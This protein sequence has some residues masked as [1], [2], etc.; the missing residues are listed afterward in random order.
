MKN[1]RAK[2]A[3]II[4]SIVFVF[5][6]CMTVFAV[7]PLS[8][9]NTQNGIKA[10][11][12]FNKQEYNENEN[13]EV[14]F[15]VEN[16]NSYAV[17]NLQTELIV[18]NTMKLSKGSLKQE[19]F[20]L[21]AGESKVQEVAL[22][23]V[24]ETNNNVPTTN[25][26]NKTNNPQTGNNVVVYIA[27]MVVSAVA[28]VVIAVKKNWIHQKKVMSLVLCFTLVG[29]MNLTSVVNAEPTIK[30]FTVEGTIKYDG[31]DVVIKGKVTDTHEIYSKLQI[32]GEDKGMY[33]EGDTVT[34]TAE[35]APE[36][37]HFSGWTVVKG[38]VTLADENSSTTTFVMG[39]EEVEIKSNYE[40][41]KYTIEVTSGEN[42]KVSP[43]GSISVN[44]GENQEFTITANTGYHIEKVVVDGEDKG[45]I[46]SY[47]FENIKETHTINATFAINTMYTCTIKFFVNGEE[48]SSSSG[49]LDKETVDF[50][51]YTGYHIESVEV[52]G[53][54]KGKITSYTFDDMSK[55][56]T[57]NVY[58][59]AD[60]F[61]I[62][63][64]TNAGGSI[65]GNTTVNYNDN[66]TF[67]ITPNT[68][69][70]IVAVK[71][72]GTS[73][74]AVTSYEF[75][76][77]VE[78]HTIEV[79]F[80]VTTEESFRN[81]ISDGGTVELASN[82]NLTSSILQL[83]GVDVILEG[84]NYTV[85]GIGILVCDGAEL[86]CKDLNSS[87]ELVAARGDCGIE[88][89]PRY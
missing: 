54:N 84:N 77:V 38:N 12:N 30:E 44:Y 33:I 59:I 68:G 27:M 41:N 81:A 32:D 58:L 6:T 78:N 1:K 74:G 21:N 48:H 65:I 7:T 5:S 62:T 88:R 89:S 22:E 31:E 87:L 9:S 43:A 4:L 13:V 63:A 51:P 8:V 66:T 76:N 3:F 35:D 72:D 85:S 56:H 2:I 82:I 15:S 52:D 83:T 18:P 69:Y 16:T 75:K 46:D 10:T 29:A 28:L 49:I 53:I 37:K 25:E 34:I 39:T 73:V 50:P 17:E 36:G 79:I 61:T 19:V 80:G 42:G 26:E 67:T 64:K 60:T 47:T 20:A 14:I 70:G 24:V 11:L 40:V 71:V 45:T 86:T 23:K 57:I 55:S